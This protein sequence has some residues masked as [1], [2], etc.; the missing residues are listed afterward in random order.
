VKDNTNPK[1][2]LHLPGIDEVN[3][4]ISIIGK[5]S[6]NI[7][8]SSISYSKNGVDFTPIDKGNVFKFS[9][10][11]GEDEIFPKTFTVRAKD[12]ADNY[13]DIFPIFNINSEKD[14][15]V[16]QI[17]T[18]IDGEIIRN[19]FIISGM[20]FDDDSVSSILYSL[21]GEDFR[22][23]EKN[24]SNFSLNIPLS[25]IENNSHTIRVKAIDLLGV[26][27]DIKESTFKV[28]K[29]EP[30]SILL[31]PKIDET[32]RSIVKLSGTSSD[33][34][35]IDSVY[36]STDNGVSYQKA[37]GTEEWNFNFNTKNIK[38]G[39]YS[40][41]IKAID[42]LQTPGFYS[43]LIN[44]DNTP[45]ELIITEPFDG[46]ILSDKIVFSGRSMD[47]IG[48]K[49]VK[50]KIYNHS[51]D[52]K[53]NIVVGQGAL[54]SGGIFNVEIPLDG[55]DVGDYNIELIAYDNADNRS[56]STRNF[57]VTASD[58]AGDL[59]LLFPQGGSSQTSIFEVSGKVVGRKK[60]ESVECFI[61]DKLFSQIKVNEFNY[62]NLA[63]DTLRLS[64]GEHKVQVTANLP[65]GQVY[66]S[67]VIMFSV[68]N[69]GPW[70]NII[71]MKTGDNI[72]NRPFL[73]GE[74]G[75]IQDIPLDDPEFVR[76]SK[77]EVSLDNGQRFQPAVGSVN[78]SFRIETWQYDDGL[79]PILVR[80]Y[81]SNGET[82]TAKI[83]VNIDR[84]KPD[85]NVLE[86]LEQ[87]RFNQAISISGT[88]FDSNGLTD[89]SVV[90]RDGNKSSYQ[91]PGLFQGMFVDV[92]TSYGKTIEAG[93]GLTFFDDNVKLQFIAGDT[94]ILSEEA[95]IK[96]MFYGGK[97]LANLYTLEFGSFLGPDWNFF[98][99]SLGLGASF[100]Q[101]TL[102]ISDIDYS[103]WYSAI[104]IQY[105]FAKF[106]LNNEYFSSVSLF[107]ELE[108]T[109]ISSENS[110][111]FYPRIGIGSRFGL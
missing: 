80:A 38:D 41:F 59:E 23:I 47:N 22:V 31:L 2:S 11:F 44:I 102:T 43:T 92:T 42:K 30:S 85:V 72:S 4:V 51:D 27:S 83:A 101:K 55:Y 25:S 81:Y 64:N 98:S 89:I 13:S 48:L 50:Y 96:G 78:W 15:P 63:I 70:L 9:L 62:Y 21:D 32:K 34:N 91:I 75:Y 76:P 33:K 106:K 86:D 17:Q 94:R 108:A 109:L 53:E 49:E 7:E 93:I 10:D 28:S 71:N 65:D 73:T 88:A 46:D 35:G 87:G 110:G 99:M 74:A 8:L 100:T 69:T 3:G 20:A 84:S 58:D 79:T 12:M 104:V 24:K 26:E 57:S 66:N 95:R 77:V 105:E 14:K 6:D 61:D 54:S 5:S 60:V 45:P 36:V 29:E 103:M 68:K 82:Q 67:E 19:D 40:I 107:S 37:N 56:I 18:P 16:V 39:T 97:L 111:G 90:L 1:I 52:N